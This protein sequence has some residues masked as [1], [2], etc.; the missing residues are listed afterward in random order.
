MKT[1]DIFIISGIISDIKRDLNHYHLRSNRFTWR[2]RDVQ[3]YRHRVVDHHAHPRPII[4]NG[5]PY[6][7][8]NDG[9]EERERESLW[10]GICIERKSRAVSRSTRLHVPNRRRNRCWE[11]DESL[12]LSGILTDDL[13]ETEGWSTRVI[14]DR[15]PRFIRFK[16]YLRTS[17]F[18]RLKISIRKAKS[19]TVST[20]KYSIRAATGHLRNCGFVSQPWLMFLAGALEYCR[21]P[22]AESWSRGWSNYFPNSGNVPR[23]GS[24]WETRPTIT[25]R[26]RSYNES[27]PLPAIH[28]RW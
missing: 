18:H 2:L 14:N 12:L 3:R 1:E 22:R 28:R 6:Y 20:R 17:C 21:L 16:I 24:L 7:R 9:R 5:S 11:K 23:L 26:P 19:I 27:Y 13:S 25:T 4:S 8:Q 15:C 10:G